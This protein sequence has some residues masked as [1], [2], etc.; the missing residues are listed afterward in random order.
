[1]ARTTTPKPAPAAATA[2][3]WVK[4]AADTN[5]DGAGAQTNADA[6]EGTTGAAAGNGGGANSGATADAET[7]AASSVINTTADVPSADGPIPGTDTDDVD[8][9]NTHEEAERLADTDVAATG[10]KELPSFVRDQVSPSGVD[11]ALEAD[12][13]TRPPL[14]RSAYPS[15]G[16]RLYQMLGKATDEQQARFEDRMVEIAEDVID[17]F[18]ATDKSAEINDRLIDGSAHYG[19]GVRSAAAQKASQGEGA[20]RVEANRRARR[21][22]ERIAA[23]SKPR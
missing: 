12:R 17:E 2:Q 15:L 7:V 9:H 5:A 19:P 10:D 20:T 18:R 8:V 22:A 21:A 1:M 3:P 16:E 13:S 4:P 6:A 23:A 14:D 11:I